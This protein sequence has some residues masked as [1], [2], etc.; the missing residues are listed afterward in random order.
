MAAA[1]TRLL[2]RTRRQRSAAGYRGGLDRSLPTVNGWAMR[3]KLLPTLRSLA[4][5]ILGKTG[6]RDR[7]DTATRMATEADFSDKG[8]PSAPEREP[9]PH[10]DP[11]D[12]LMG[13]VGEPEPRSGPRQAKARTLPDRRRRYRSSR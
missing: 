6:K 9:A 10:I 4:N 11:I 12:E 13:T 2:R 3:R 1:G 8:E 5:A 7:L